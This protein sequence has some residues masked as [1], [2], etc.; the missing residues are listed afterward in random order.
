MKVLHTS[1]RVLFASS[2]LLALA[3]AHAA[4]GYSVWPRDE[5]KVKTGMSMDE[6]RQALGEP[7]RSAKY[8]NEPGP[9]WTYT[10]NG[11][12]NPRAVFEV[13]FSADGTVAS[14]DQRVLASSSGGYH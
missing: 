8:R 14:V 9:T 12:D 4:N 11:Y 13:D 7:S 10:V 1:A 3:G 2:L 5:G 6:V